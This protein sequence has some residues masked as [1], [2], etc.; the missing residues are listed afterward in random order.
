M[1]AKF[2][3]YTVVY[4]SICIHQSEGTDTQECTHN[5][6]YMHM[7]H[8]NMVYIY[9]QNITHMHTHQPCA[10]RMEMVLSI[11]QARIVMT[12]LW[13]CCFRL[14]L[15]W[16]CRTRW[17]VIIIILFICNLC[18]AMHIIHCTLSITQYSGEY[19]CQKT[20]STDNCC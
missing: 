7:Q 8:T 4:L 11:L 3:R 17:K 15:L 5:H 6:T 13:R 14:G 10:R 1:P 9:A 19:E 16:T 18:C 2:S 20:Y 12:G